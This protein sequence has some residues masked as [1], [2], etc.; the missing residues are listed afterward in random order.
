L[1]YKLIEQSM[2]WAMAFISGLTKTLLAWR[3]HAA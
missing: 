3:L 1:L 2:L